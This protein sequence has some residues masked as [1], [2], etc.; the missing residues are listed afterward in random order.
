LPGAV[1][2]I[3]GWAVADGPCGRCRVERSAWPVIYPDSSF[4]FFCDE[5]LA[6]VIR[7][8]R[9]AVSDERGQPPVTFSE[10]LAEVYAR[11]GQGP[12][13]VVTVAEKP[14]LALIAAKHEC[15]RPGCGVAIDVKHLACRA[16][17]F[18]LKL[19]APDIAK[20]ARWAYIGR[21]QLP[22]EYR[23][24]LAAARAWW[25]AKDRKGVAV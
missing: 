6:V 2:T 4:D 16:H 18:E 17:W 8:A 13:A 10:W 20:A 21:S 7:R 15:C 12:G 25:E 1:L 22:D 14:P 19:G 24:A 5:C 23:E 11:R 3:L 9:G